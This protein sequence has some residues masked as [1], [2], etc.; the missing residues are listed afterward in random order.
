MNTFAR[1]PEGRLIFLASME[2]GLR[3]FT[4]LEPRFATN[5]LSPT[6]PRMQVRR[7]LPQAQSGAD[8]ADGGPLKIRDQHGKDVKVNII[9][10][11][12]Y[13]AKHVVD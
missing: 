10:R 4:T 9:A 7:Y 3:F 12:G 13:T 1:M 5:T 11:E 6:G 8:A 2:N